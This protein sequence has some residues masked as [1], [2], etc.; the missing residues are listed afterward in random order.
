MNELSLKELEKKLDNGDTFLLYTID[1]DKSDIEKSNIIEEIDK[2]VKES[3]Q[4]AYYVIV[5]EGEKE[6]V[7]QIME[8]YKHP[9]LKRNGEGLLNLFTIVYKQGITDIGVEIDFENMLSSEGDQ[10]NKEDLYDEIGEVIDY[11]EFHNIA[12][13]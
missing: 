6:E 9:D 2:Y 8:S 13:E 3:N 7:V 10:Y 1:A 5:Q 11:V 12:V 4:K